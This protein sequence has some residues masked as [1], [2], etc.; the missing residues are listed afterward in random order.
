MWRKFKRDFL[1]V[2]NNEEKIGREGRVLMR[3]ILTTQDIVE[4]FKNMFIDNN[5]EI[6]LKHR[7]DGEEESVKLYEYL[8]LHLYAWKNRLVEING[9]QIYYGAWSESL[10][11][12]MG[13]TYGLV[14]KENETAVASSD[15]D[16]NTIEGTITFNV[17][18]NKINNLDYYIQKIRNVYL[19]NPQTIQNRY[20]NNISSFIVIGLL[21]YDTEPQ[22]TPYGEMIEASVGFSISYINDAE[23]YKDTKIELSLDNEASYLTMPICGVTFK[24]MFTTTPVPT[25]SLPNMTGVLSSAV[26]TGVTISFYDWNLTLSKSINEILYGIGAY[27]INNVAQIIKR[28]KYPSIFKSHK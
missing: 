16:S 10:D 26:T 15:I 5:E 28:N 22:M 21:R 17:P 27:K 20:G 11:Y 4:M 9:S 18:S 1:E 24:T 25:A 7:P 3:T 2:M 8:N 23:T 12:S 6:L 13:Q 14:E 19:G